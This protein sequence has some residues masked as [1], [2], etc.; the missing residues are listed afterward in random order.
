MFDCSRNASSWKQILSVD[1][2]SS[3]F[4][5]QIEDIVYITD[6]G[7]LRLLAQ[8]YNVYPKSLIC[9]LAVCCQ[10][11]KRKLSHLPLFACL[12]RTDCSHFFLLPFAFSQTT[13]GN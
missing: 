9:N 13:C 4:S 2:Y 8:F 10:Y 1:K 5:R 11:S 12:G 7:S 3:I 6:M